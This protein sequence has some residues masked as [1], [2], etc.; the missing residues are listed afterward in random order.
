MAEGVTV[1]TSKVDDHV[2]V[3]LLGEVD[4]ANVDTTRSQVLSAAA[5]D[6]GG[7]IVDLSRT[8]YLDSSGIRMLFEIE[9]ELTALRITFD[10]VVPS[11]SMVHRV[12]ELTG[13]LTHMRCRTT[14]NDAL[15]AER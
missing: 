4:M 7:V 13:V 9:E 5:D 6:P 8:T 3:L 15:N 2:V 12:L 1:E 11:A 14:V 10:L